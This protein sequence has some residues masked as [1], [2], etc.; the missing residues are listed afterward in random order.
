MY[1]SCYSKTGTCSVQKSKI[2]IYKGLLA[3]RNLFSFR[4]DLTIAG[5]GVLR[6]LPPYSRRYHVEKL[7]C[8]GHGLHL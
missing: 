6:G 3:K 5:I 1:L 4:H 7:E 2:H 8:S